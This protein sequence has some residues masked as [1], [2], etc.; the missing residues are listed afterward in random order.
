MRILVTGANGQLGSDV[1]DCLLQNGHEVIRA[2][3]EDCDITDAAAVYGYFDSV[4]P[5][6][7]IHCAAYTAVDR[8]ESDR[9]AC[10][11]VNVT[12]SENVAKAAEKH[13]AKCVY[14][15]SDYVFDGEGEIPFETDGKKGPKNYYGLTKL[16][17]ENATLENCTRAFIV[18][19]SWVFGMNGGNF[20]K[21]IARISAE[22]DEINVVDDQVGSPTYTKDVSRVLA[23]MVTTEKYGV[24]HVTN[25]GF[26]SWREFAG[27]IIKIT[28]ENCRV[29]PVTSAE[30]PRPAL[31]PLNS[32]LSKRSLD[33]NGFDRL[34]PWQ[35]ALARFLE[36]YRQ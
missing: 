11:A 13:R 28:G 15:S 26:C 6:A 25:E 23:E 22:N 34:P 2:H 20:V 1:V 21:T 7:V 9:E 5:E 17:G 36:E 27:E 18:R 16:E 8:A 12:G 29:N 4:A 3:K 14:I 31:R 24:Y 32:R 35:N 33:E 30:Y 19:I 10:F